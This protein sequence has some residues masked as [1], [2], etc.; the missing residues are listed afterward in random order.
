MKTEQ[1]VHVDR[2]S[3]AFGSRPALQD[4][5]LDVQR[6]T[7][8]G[9]LGRN[10][11]GKTTLLR[12]I[13]GLLRADSGV[14]HVF[15][16]SLQDGTIEMRSRVAYVPQEAKLFHR[17]SLERHAGLLRRFYPKFDLQLARTLAGR[18]EVHWTDSFATLSVGSR[19]KAA[20]V[21]A[22]ASG[23]DLL[24]LDEPAAGLDPLARRELYE[25]LIDSLGEGGE[26]TVLLSTHLVGDLERLADR[27][28]ILH[29]G[30]TLHVDQVEGYTERFVRVQIIFPD[31]VPMDFEIPGASTTRRE[32]SVAIGVVDVESAGDGLAEFEAGSELRLQRFPLQLEDVFIELVG[33]PTTTERENLT[34]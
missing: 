26:R 32:G 5:S 30:R 17:L 13:M 21:L 34:P 28:A 27:V 16:S 1:A 7:V 19:R 8:V 12:S 14:A 31:A 10:G 4:L 20:V 25:L 23:A 15:G 18:L 6:G 2:L 9:L 11:A 29:E 33:K 24:V 22:L 3:K